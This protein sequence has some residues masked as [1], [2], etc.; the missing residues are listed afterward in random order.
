M[1]KCMSGDSTCQAVLGHCD[2]GQGLLE[3]VIPRAGLGH[4]VLHLAQL[5][6]S[7]GLVGWK[8]L[9]LVCWKYWSLQ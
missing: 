1:C 3:V 9:G 8:S 2:L 6:V 7:G 5:D 4:Q